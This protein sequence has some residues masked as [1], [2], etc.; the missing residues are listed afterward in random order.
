MCRRGDRQAE[1]LYQAEGQLNPHA[2][3]TQR[4]KLKKRAKPS[5]QNDAFDFYVLED[6]AEEEQEDVQ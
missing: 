4:K 6:D 1:T 2:A 3:R 5:P